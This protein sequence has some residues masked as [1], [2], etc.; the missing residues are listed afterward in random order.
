[1]AKTTNKTKRTDIFSIDPR[2]I[3]VPEGFNSR[4]DFGNIDELAEEIK[5]A[6]MLNPITVQAVKTE[7]D[8]EKYS[9]VDGERRYRAIMKLIENGEQIKGKDIDYIKAIIIPSNLSKQELYVQQAM[10]NEGKNFNEYEW[11][12]L[13]N[14]LR[15][16]CGITNVSEIARMLGKNN[17]VV[18]YWLQILELPEKFQEL[19]RTGKLCGSDLRRVLQ[20]NGRNTDEAWV[21]IEKLQ[22]H[23]EEKGEEKLSLKDLDKDYNSK[24]KLF[25][26]SKTLLKGLNVLA[27]YAAHYKQEGKKLSMTMNEMHKALK[28]GKLLDEIFQAA[29]DESAEDEEV[30]ETA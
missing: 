21:D 23:A 12:I 11:A 25:K 3:I 24:T 20:A 27:E 7:N 14:K 2:N 15:T 28:D 30:R 13:A 29:L 9:L 6:G 10:R 22:M 8:E 5:T 1:M 19:V 17:G 4:I 18:I 26:D 16:E